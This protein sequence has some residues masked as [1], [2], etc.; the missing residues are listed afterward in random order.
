M[1]KSDLLERIG[2][3]RQ[4]PTQQEL[5][6]LFQQRNILQFDETPV[7]QAGIS[8]IDLEKVDVLL[9]R[10]GQT[11]LDRESRT[12]LVQ[13]L[14]N[15]SIV[16]TIDRQTHPTLAGLLA[17]GKNPQRFFPSFS[18]MC[19]AYRGSDLVSDTVAE[20]TISGS[21]DKLIEDTMAFL[22][23]VVP[24]DPRAADGIKRSDAF[25]YPIEALREGVVNAVCHRDYTISG[26]AI[27]VFV[28]A[29]HI[30]IRSPGNL[31]NTLTLES[32]RFRQF[33]R[34][35]VIA[36]FLAGMGYMERRGK[37][38]LRIYQQCRAAGVAGRF[39]LTPDN[40]E[41]VLTMAAGKRMDRR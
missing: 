2:S 33:S 36:S 3:A 19:G 14:N 27:R 34:N 31:P 32:M 30:E 21:F 1:N 22:R 6:R 29:D 13:D 38:I 35:Q 41:L 10:L 40:S 39:D 8:D 5:L 11:P 23:L 4:I 26:A 18:V 24:Q 7:L 28:F 37:G 17:F 16:L 9:G 20:K 15:L 12:A 25:Q